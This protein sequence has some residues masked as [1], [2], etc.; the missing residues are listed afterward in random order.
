MFELK[1]FKLKKFII[2]KP[3]HKN[4]HSEYSDKFLENSN[5]NSN[6]EK[7]KRN[8]NLPFNKTKYSNYKSMLKEVLDK[9]K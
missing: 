5:I 8:N 3:H 7:S 6:E 1:I 4:K 2:E 9:K